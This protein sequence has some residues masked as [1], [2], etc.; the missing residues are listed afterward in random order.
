M[1]LL[2]EYWNTLSQSK[3]M[4]VSLV[5]GMGSYGKDFDFDR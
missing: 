1:R 4:V 2:S 5:K 3:D